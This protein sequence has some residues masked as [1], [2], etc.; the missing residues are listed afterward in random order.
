LKEKLFTIITINILSAIFLVDSF[1]VLHNAIT[2]GYWGLEL[3]ESLDGAL[4]LTEL[5]V[6]WAK[7]CA[8]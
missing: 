4:S 7:L 8:A 3:S 5:P 6:P 2:L 1:E